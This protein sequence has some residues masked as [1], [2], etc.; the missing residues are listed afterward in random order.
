[1]S[2]DTASDIW[3]VMSTARAIRRYTDAP[4][5]DD[6]VMRCLEAATWAPSGG[7]QQPWRFVVLQS[8]ELRTIIAEGARQSWEIMKGFYGI[9]VPDPHDTSPRSR[10]LRAMHHSMTNAESVPVCI[11][12]CVDPQRGAS[13]LEQ[14]ASIYPAMQNFLLAA[15]AQ[16]L[17]AA[18]ALWHRMVEPE[19]RAALGM[20]ERWWIAATMTAGWPAG[21]HGPLD[22]RPVEGVVSVDTW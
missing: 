7:N 11:I 20:P 10:T 14:G 22:R 17:G 15:R 6:V 12:F 5:D 3:T 19:L 16:G 18:T 9:D 4:V 1:M 8:A 21:H 13:D 2:T